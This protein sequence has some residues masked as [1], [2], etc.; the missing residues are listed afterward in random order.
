MEK[1]PGNGGLSTTPDTGKHSAE[2]SSDRKKALVFM[3]AAIAFIV[4][5]KYLLGY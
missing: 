1:I 4:G 3:L 5:L 2:A